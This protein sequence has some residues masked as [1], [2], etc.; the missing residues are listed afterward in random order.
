MKRNTA[1]KRMLPHQVDKLSIFFQLFCSP[2]I[3]S[4][5]M[6]KVPSPSIFGHLSIDKL[7]LQMQREEMVTLLLQILLSCVMQYVWCQVCS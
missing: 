4:R 6:L 3:C 1:H 2:L 5:G 7:K